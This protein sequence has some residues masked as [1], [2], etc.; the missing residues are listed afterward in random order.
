MHP[1]VLHRL[2]YPALFIVSF[3]FVG[4]L[5]WAISANHGSSGSLVNPTIKLS[6][7]ETGF[8]L[9]SGACGVAGSYTGASIRISDWTRFAKKR[10][11]PTVPMVLAM[12]ITFTISSVFGVIVASAIQARYGVLQWNPIFLMQYI[13][14]VDYTPACRAGTFFAGLAFLCSQIFVSCLPGSC[15]ACRVAH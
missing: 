14:T 15:L 13:Q 3:A 7:V 11:A 2:L 5:G 12:P 6:S 8:S 10:N 1:R 9:M 4:V